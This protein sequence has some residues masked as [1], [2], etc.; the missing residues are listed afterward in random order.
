MSSALDD[1]H[2]LPPGVDIPD[3]TL[4]RCWPT[5][6]SISTDGEKRGATEIC[7][8]WANGNCVRGIHCGARHALPSMADENRLYYSED[9]L[10]DVFGRGRASLGT[11]TSAFDPLAC[12]IIHVKSGV[13]AGTL[14]QR[15][16]IIDE[17]FAEWGQVVKTWFLADEGS[18]FLR[19]KWRSS[20]QVVMEALHGRPLRPED[21][22]PM[23]LAWATVD[24]SVIQATQGKELAY[25]AMV[26]AR[27]R[28]NAAQALY[29]RLERER[30]APEAGGGGGS[31]TLGKRTRGDDLASDEAS[32]ASTWHTSSDESINAVASAYPG[33]LAGDGDERRA[34]ADEEHAT[35]L[36]AG[37][38]EAA[39]GKLPEG[40]C[41]GVDPTYGCTYYYHE[42]MGRTQWEHPSTT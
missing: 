11:P 23:S 38:L 26:E 17:G 31:G 29:D 39:T 19:F 30:H 15:R 34:A 28:G 13:P 25:N 8:D 12:Q 24:P 32:S 22:E 37:P 2:D 33:G 6:D 3:A 1:L 18:C 10:R 21:G 5:I 14:Q 42:A 16:A 36:A 27:Q 35:S 4:P 41:A 7:L 40:W 9:G 20:A